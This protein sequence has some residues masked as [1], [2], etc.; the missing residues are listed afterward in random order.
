VAILFALI[1][2]TGTA[3]GTGYAIGH[4]S[5]GD[6]STAAVGEAAPVA[7]GPPI[8]RAMRGRWERGKAVLA[9]TAGGLHVDDERPGGYETTYFRKATLRILAGEVTSD[10]SYRVTKGAVEASHSSDGSCRGVIELTG[11]TLQVTLTGATP[12]G[13][14]LSGAWV[15]GGSIERP[16]AEPD[17]AGR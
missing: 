1:L 6:E 11:D 9:V 15:R 12:C 13:S 3:G 10:E 2:V 5:A 4:L 16:T 17:G 14:L 7:S 8:A